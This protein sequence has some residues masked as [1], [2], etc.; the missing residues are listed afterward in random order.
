MFTVVL[1]ACV[2]IPATLNYTMLRIAEAGAYGIRRSEEVLDEVCR[3]MVRLGASEYA[4]D[5][6]V[7][8]RASADRHELS[9]AATCDSEAVPVGASVLR[10][11]QNRDSVAAESG[12][13]P[14]AELLQ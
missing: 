1:D 10:Q 9:S 3:N 8:S 13:V 7:D 5:R 12:S 4:A 11:A 14:D 6:R 2:I